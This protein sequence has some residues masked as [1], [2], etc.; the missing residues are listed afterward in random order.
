MSR[1]ST[2]YEPEPQ[3]VQRNTFLYFVLGLIALS[4]RVLA[5]ME[6]QVVTAAGASQETQ[7]D[8]GAGQNSPGDQTLHDILR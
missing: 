5:Q 6:N 7:V 3:F 4:K 2:L 1:R 8:D